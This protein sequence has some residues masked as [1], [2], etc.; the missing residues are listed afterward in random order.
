MLYARRREI[1]D[2]IAV[3]GGMLSGLAGESWCGLIGGDF[4]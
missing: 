2:E 4:K 1:M 3:H